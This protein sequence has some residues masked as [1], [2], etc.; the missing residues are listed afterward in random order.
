M[1]HQVWAVLCEQK[2]IHLRTHVEMT[3]AEKGGSAGGGW[4]RGTVRE[5][6][7]FSLTMGFAFA[8]PVG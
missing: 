2:V 5:P 8:P 3:H 7:G 6:E 4:R 1:E